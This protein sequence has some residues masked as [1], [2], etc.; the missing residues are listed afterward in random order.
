MIS[1]QVLKRN[2]EELYENDFLDNEDD[3]HTV[4]KELDNIEY[5]MSF[6]E[7][8]DDNIS[9]LLYPNI[10]LIHAFMKKWNVSSIYEGK[11]WIVLLTS[12]NIL[13]DLDAYDDAFSW[14]RPCNR[15]YSYYEHYFGD[16]E[17]ISRDA[18]QYQDFYKSPDVPKSVQVYGDMIKSNSEVYLKSLDNMVL[19]NELKTRGLSHEEIRELKKISE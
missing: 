16:T 3:E 2:F 14:I 9:L 4:R 5:Y 15:S 1:N 13:M 8:I 10:P 12:N 7:G 6:K 19:I 18:Y 11:K 17:D